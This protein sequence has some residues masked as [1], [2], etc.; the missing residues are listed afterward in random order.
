MSEQQRD[1][2]LRLELLRLRGQV[3]RADCEAARD[4][5]R[6]ATRGVRQVV[7]VAMDW[8]SAV[9]G[10]A[11]WAAPLLGALRERPW[12]LGMAGVAWRS[13]RRH[14]LGAAVTVAA[15][16]A[17]CIA[18]RAGPSSRPAGSPPR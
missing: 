9:R 15:V 8:S 10:R 12:L 4:E 7:S 17:A 3:Q 16:V 18:W 5:L 2:R 1:L 11:G 6:A 13:A 14:P